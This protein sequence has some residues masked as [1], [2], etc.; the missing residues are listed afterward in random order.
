MVESGTK[1]YTHAQ[2]QGKPKWAK[3]ST[4]LLPKH[5]LLR[6]R[7]VGRVQCTETCSNLSICFS[8]HQLQAHQQESKQDE[9]LKSSL[10]KLPGMKIYFLLKK[11]FLLFSSFLFLC[12]GT[13]FSLPFF[14]RPPSSSHLGLTNDTG[15]PSISC[16]PH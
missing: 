14:L 6:G 5:I 1:T 13:F 15:N 7:E 9:E 4:H 10:W 2:K 3:L 11:K 8:V 16:Y 12:Y